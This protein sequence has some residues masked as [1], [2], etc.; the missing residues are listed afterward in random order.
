MIEEIYP[1]PSFPVL[2]VRNLQASAKWYQEALGFAHIFTMPGPGGK[3]GGVVPRERHAAG[4]TPA[5]QPAL[6]HLRWMKYADLLIARPRDGKDIPEPRGAGVALNF[7]MFGRPDESVD[8]LA[9][10]AKEHG[11][12]IAAGPLD[13]PWNVRELTVLDPDG[14]RLVFS[15]P[16]NIGLGFDKML[17]RVVA[18]E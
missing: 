8:A 4:T 3:S 10:R 14:Y 7:N 6:V 13:Q 2:I 5:A 17:E 15:A 18:E 11:A 16:I 1:M 9:Q 12:T